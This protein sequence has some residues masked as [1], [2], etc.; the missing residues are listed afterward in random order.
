MSK[1]GLLPLIVTLLLSL[2]LSSIVPMRSDASFATCT[3]A[4]PCKACKNCRHCRHCAREGG[5]AASLSV[6]KT[7]C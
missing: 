3:G 6:D 1:C 4:D 2:A 5:T 7:Q